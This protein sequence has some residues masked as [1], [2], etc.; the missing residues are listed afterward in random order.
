MKRTLKKGE[1]SMGITDS[2]WI[3][4]APKVFQDKGTTHLNEELIHRLQ[5][6]KLIK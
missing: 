1:F 3:S 5:F 6:P 4:V 2:R